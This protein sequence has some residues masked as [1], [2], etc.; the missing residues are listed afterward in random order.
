MQVKKFEA[1]TMKEALELV[2]SQLGPDAIILSAR[3]NNKSYGLVGEG[4][5]EVTAAVSEET[6]HKKKFTE[7][8]LRGQDLET[9][10]R[11]TARSQKNIIDKMVTRYTEKTQPRPSTARRYIDIADDHAQAP[12]QP[13]SSASTQSS[14]QTAAA[15]KVIS[16]QDVAAHMH[17]MQKITP[18]QE[19]NEMKALKEEI[20]TLRGMISQFKDIPQNMVSTYPGADYGLPFDLSW[21]YEKLT[22]VGV[23]DLVAAEIL[24]RAQEVIPAL[25]LKNKNLLEA[26]VARHLLETAMIVGVKPVDKVQVFVGPSGGGKTTAMIKMASKL[27][28]EEKKKI[29]ILT[30]DT[31]KVGATDQMRIYAQ[32]LNV[33]FAIIR[34]ASDWNDVMNYLSR[35][36]CILVDMPSLSLKNEEEVKMLKKLM[37]PALL[38]PR[39]HYVVSVTSKD[40]DI[41]DSAQRYS[42]LGIDDVIFTSLDESARHGSIYNFIHRFNKP[43]HS[44][45]IGPNVPEDYEYA[46]KERILD[47]LFRLTSKSQ[48]LEAR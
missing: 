24:T 21:M 47:L 8:R 46:T 37:P 34:S 23:A 11:S 16:A 4:S 43:V 17:T 41:H 7:S 35:I 44:F 2:K 28:I 31:L 38:N 39:V 9:F 30:T 12:A 29:A 26:W 22:T 27:V 40:A 19:S 18:A 42:V 20:N 32:I 1:K 48:E 14:P 45:G 3:D 33:P 15:S 10:N 5:V 13:S 36:D 25:K 6:L